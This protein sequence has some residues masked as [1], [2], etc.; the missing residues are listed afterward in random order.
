MEK[1]ALGRK[2]ESLFSEIRRKGINIGHGCMKLQ[3]L[4][5]KRMR[6]I[7]SEGIWF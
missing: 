5:M 4:Q 7:T 1:L 6:K 2:K 3:Q